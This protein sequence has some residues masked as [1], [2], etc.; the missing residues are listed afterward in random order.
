MKKI[1]T[2]QKTKELISNNMIGE[3]VEDYFIKDIKIG[4]YF[5]LYD[6]IVVYVGKSLNI[7]SRL[8][9]HL[10]SDK[11]FNS[12]YYLVSEKEELEKREKEY[13][14]MFIPIYNKDKLVMLYKNWKVK[15]KLIR[16]ELKID[17]NIK[18]SNNQILNELLFWSKKFF[19]E[20]LQNNHKEYE[21]ILV[22]V[23]TLIDLENI[24][25]RYRKKEFKDFRELF[26]PIIDFIY[27]VLY[28]K[29]YHFKN[30]NTNH[31]NSHIKLNLKNLNRENLINYYTQIKDFFYFIDINIKEYD[32]FQFNIGYTKSGI[33]MKKPF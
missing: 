16:L 18:E 31:L 32:Y 9:Q 22:N 25:L 6:N 7:F 14:I 29:I 21:Q 30:I 5:L 17:V 19:T 13:I 28:I 27:Y 26:F 3:K 15:K 33:E 23:K 24:L 11:I 2:K 4:I 1:I 10:K 8:R 20:I 12:A